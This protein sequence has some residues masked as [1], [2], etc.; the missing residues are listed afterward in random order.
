MSDLIV[1]SLTPTLTSGPGL[2]TYGVIA[3][4]AR[5]RPVEV[6]YMVWGADRPAARLQRLPDV[7]LRAM[8]STRGP[9]RLL[10]FARACRRGLP[11]GL[12]RG[13]APAL[14]AAARGAPAGVRVIADGPVVAA[15]L[16]PIA[17]RRELVYLAHN[18]ESSGFRL[19]SERAGLERF[20]RAVLQT[21]SEC[22]MAT[23]ADE[24]GARLL[25][26]DLVTTRYVPSVIDV[27]LIEPVS[28]A[29]TGQLLFVGDLTW[30]PNAEALAFLAQEVLPAVWERWPEVQLRAVGRGTPKV[31]GTLR[32]SRIA[33]AG[34]VDDLAREYASADV[35]LVPLLRGGGSP[36]KFVEG[37]TYGLPVVAT[38]HAAGLLEDG[39]P[40]RDFIAAS[41]ALGFAAGIE[42]LLADPVRAAAVGAAGRD[43]AVKRYSVDR[44]ATLLAER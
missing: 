24:R 16:L 25:A 14:A 21:F 18:V 15:G 30:P 6:A 3:A 23:R 36:L 33:L 9:A 1:T 12:A 13:V 43:L 27:G 5:D 26:G 2:R 4:L 32:D 10:T 17:R 35:A 31:Q 7:T 44:L 37:L 39:V 41:D 38:A 8:R 29:R 11:A 28:P 42:S 34:F 20:E 22:W 40:G 19:E